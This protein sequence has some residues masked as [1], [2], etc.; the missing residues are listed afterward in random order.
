M[1]LRLSSFFDVV[2]SNVLVSR[3]ASKW[4][5]VAGAVLEPPRRRHSWVVG[6]RVKSR[7][8]VGIGVKEAKVEVLSDEP[9]P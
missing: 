5:R 9:H 3:L 6:S 8:M 1:L 2:R 4:F 7:V